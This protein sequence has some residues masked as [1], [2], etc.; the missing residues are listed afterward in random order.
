MKQLWR[1]CS[2]LGVVTVLVGCEN[3]FFEP[4]VRPIEQGLGVSVPIGHA[5]ALA[6]AAFDGDPSPCAQLNAGGVVNLT[7]DQDCPIPLLP[8]A[9][10]MITVTGAMTSPTSGLFAA[11][12]TEID[13]DGRPLMLERINAFLVTRFSMDRMD[14]SDEDDNLKVIFYDLDLEL[15]SR[16]R[17]EFAQSM[18]LVDVDR[19]ST[20]GVPG[21]DTMVISGLRQ[22]AGKSG[23]Q[24]AFADQT[25]LAGAFIDSECQRN[26]RRGFG[27]IESGNSGSFADNGITIVAFTPECDGNARILLSAGLG[28]PSTGT[29]V[30]LDLLSR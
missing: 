5:A 27:L 30:E 15:P 14:P 1:I 22:G 7:V 25:L 4:S 12:F 19:G 6:V 2:F 8:M 3:P 21:D 28:A 20:P 24:Q 11:V 16:E 10:G 13:V 17:F 26:P 23:A 9:R 18:W 29:R